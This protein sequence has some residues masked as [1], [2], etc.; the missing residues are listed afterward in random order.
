MTNKGAGSY[1]LEC[2]LHGGEVYGTFKNRGAKGRAT[3]C[4][5]WFSAFA[6]GAEKTSLASTAHDAGKKRLIVQN[7]EADMKTIVVTAFK[8][9]EQSPPKPFTLPNTPLRMGQFGD[10]ETQFKAA[11]VGLEINP[12]DLSNPKFVNMRLELAEDA[13]DAAA[14]AGAG[15]DGGS[16]SGG[17][18]GESEA[19]PAG[20]EESA[21]GSG[22]DGSGGGKGHTAMPDFDSMPLEELNKLAHNYGMSAFRRVKLAVKK[23]KECWVAAQ[24][25]TGDEEEEE[26]EEEEQ[27]QPPSK[28]PRVQQTLVAKA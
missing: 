12:K 5:N 3:K 26:E 18:G 20:E 15:E 24:Q 25:K 8:P 27:Q 13:E 7:I 16:G 14:G 11:S 28:R 6:T 21:G 9:V 1:Y 17:G 2:M 23:I 4:F 22:G 19:P 10:H